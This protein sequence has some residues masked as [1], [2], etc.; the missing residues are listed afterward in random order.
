M[1]GVKSPWKQV[2]ANCS[3]KDMTRLS[4]ICSKVK[5]GLNRLQNNYIN[6]LSNYFYTIAKIIEENFI[7]LYH[8]NCTIKISRF[9]R[10]LSC[11]MHVN[12]NR[13][14]CS[15]SRILQ[16]IQI[17]ENLAPSN[18]MKTVSEY[19]FITSTVFCM[20]WSVQA[21]FFKLISNS[22]SDN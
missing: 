16:L 19:F 14:M 9:E 15:V 1:G 12:C 17:H 7:R 6:F 2:I 8:K 11:K 13:S 21:N 20:V 18:H 4:H 5:I 10:Q 3:P 22:C